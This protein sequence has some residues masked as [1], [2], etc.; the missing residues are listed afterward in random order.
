MKYCFETARFAG[1]EIDVRFRA[2][3]ELTDYGVPR[4]PQFFELDPGTT[5]VELLEILGV[6]C[7]LE[8]LPE[9]LQAAVLKLAD[10]CDFQPEGD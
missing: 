4:S 9:A 3:A 8:E 1:E 5:E 7:K 10:E 2:R 6:E